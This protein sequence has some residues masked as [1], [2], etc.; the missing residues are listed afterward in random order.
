MRTSVIP[1]PE[2]EIF[3]GIN[4]AKLLEREGTR[5]RWFFVVNTLNSPSLREKV[6]R[7]IGPLTNEELR[8]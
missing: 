5:G 6:K 8:D 7:D 4:L 1:V 3:K 2:S